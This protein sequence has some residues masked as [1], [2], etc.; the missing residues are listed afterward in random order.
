[1]PCLSR[2]CAT[3]FDAARR[4]G[5]RR[6]RPAQ[7]GALGLP[8]TASRSKCGQR[9][10]RSSPS[11]PSSRMTIV[12]RAIPICLSEEAS[13]GG[14]TTKLHSRLPVGLIATPR[15]AFSTC[16]PDEPLGAVIERNREVFDFFPVV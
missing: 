5:S 1:T 10:Q 7:D 15:G 4:L 6:S 3:P 13:S 9:L 14:S 16:M 8:V 11:T 2:S 12:G